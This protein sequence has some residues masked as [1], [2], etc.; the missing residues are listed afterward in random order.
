MSKHKKRNENIKRLQTKMKQYSFVPLNAPT[1]LTA[2]RNSEVKFKAFAT[3][4]PTNAGCIDFA[5]RTMNRVMK[6]TTAQQTK[7]KRTI[8]HWSSAILIQA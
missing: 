4:T 5:N 3:T 1:Y 2:K 8:S 7:V 6:V